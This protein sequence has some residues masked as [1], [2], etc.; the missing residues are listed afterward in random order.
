MSGLSGFFV[1]STSSRF[2]SIAMIAVLFGPRVSEGSEDNLKRVYEDE[3]LPI[4]I[5]Y[6]Y[7]CHGDGIAEGH[8]ALDD[9]ETIE[10]M[11]ADREQWQKI[12][13]HIDFRLMPPPGEFAPEAE[14]RA[15]LVR[16]IDDAVFAVDPDRPDPGHVTLRRLNRTEYQNT[17]EDL[18]GVEVGVKE[19]LPVDD[20]SHGFDNIGNMLTLSP[21]H[22]ERYL[23]AAEVALDAAVDLGPPRFAEKRLAGKMFRGMGNQYGESFILTTNGE[24]SIEQP[25]EKTG[26]YL[27]R[28]SAEG[29]Q[30]GEEPVKMSLKVGDDE[31]GLWEVAGSVGHV[32]EAEVQLDTVGPVRLGVSFLN[33]YYSED[34]ERGVRDRNLILHEVVLKGPVDGPPMEKPAS[35]TAIYGK[36]PAGLTDDEYF[37]AVIERF[38]TRAFRRPLLEGEAARYLYFL[39]GARRDGKSVE[40]AIRQAL[41]AVLVSPN[42]LFRE[43]VLDSG[44]GGGGAGFEKVR[45]GE[46]TLASRLSYFLWSSM[47]DDRLREL[48]DRGELRANLRNEIGRMLK[49]EKAQSLTENF[50]GQWL[51]LRD[52]D[53]VAPNGDVYGQLA[54]ELWED[55]RQETEM[56]FGEIVKENLPVHNLMSARYTFL[57][58]RLAEHYGIEGEFTDEFRKVDLSGTN[59]Q[60]ILGHGSFLTLSSHSRRTSPV[61][62]GKYVLEN[63]LDTPPPP[64]PPNVPALSA[65]RPKSDEVLTLRQEFEMHRE[66]PAC[67][68][69]HALMDP[70]G[71][72]LENFDGVG[73]WRE[74]DRGMPLDTADQM[75]TGQ[76]FANGAEMREILIHDFKDE[77]DRAVA[78]KLLTY[79]LGRSVEYYDRTAIEEIML[80]V[81]KEDGRFHAYIHAIAESVPFQFRRKPKE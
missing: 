36:N 45:I 11:V 2:L 44:D 37:T 77:F 26:R 71:F 68:S 7:D 46:H 63:L 35:H 16:W 39:E 55:M 51:Q 1:M 20:S 8:L 3:V 25:I 27:M 24:A 65:D 78:V 38:A 41:A 4:L 31:I 79:G 57:N 58:K 12:R 81:Q 72:G 40:E 6:C 29:Q 76:K 74:E 34:A 59:R 19:L 21:L 54:P 22:M 17:L 13:D 80:K 33:D 64:A 14:E 32:F 48:A 61:L 70:I 28:V 43:E 5:N 56:L 67:A 47:P 69:C 18:L 62:R 15:A 66:K 75:I 73:R 52:M 30:A 9:F 50:A 42:F 53:S 23:E 49:S 60:G 10:E